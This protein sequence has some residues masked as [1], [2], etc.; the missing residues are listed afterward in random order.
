VSSTTWYRHLSEAG[1]DEERAHMNTAKLDVDTNP[2]GSS[3][4]VKPRR[5]R[6]LASRRCNNVHP[7]R[8]TVREVFPAEVCVYFIF[9]LKVA[10]CM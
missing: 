3:N 2:G 4:S 7:A 8:R 9:K 10:Y 1:S 5:S 6:G